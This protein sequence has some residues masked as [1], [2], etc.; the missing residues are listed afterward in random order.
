MHK[1]NKMAQSV[2]TQKTITKI[3]CQLYLVCYPQVQMTGSLEVY[4]F[5]K[6]TESIHTCRPIKQCQIFKNLISDILNVVSEAKLKG[7][8]NQKTNYL[9][10]TWQQPKERHLT[11]EVV[12]STSQP[13]AHYHHSLRER[14]LLEAALVQVYVQGIERD[15]CRPEPCKSSV[16]SSTFSRSCANMCWHFSVVLLWH[17]RCLKGKRKGC[18]FKKRG[19]NR[20]SCA[21]HGIYHQGSSVP[22]KT[23]CISFQYSLQ[24]IPHVLQRVLCIWQNQPPH[25]LAVI[26]TMRQLRRT[27]SFSPQGHIGLTETGSPA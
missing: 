11:S 27:S 25:P 20:A 15:G 18:F 1:T 13:S 23:C 21:L 10:L 7:G 19:R 17:C 2:K 12:D 3:C 22:Y 5:I 8:Q 16:P 26:M 24:D 14:G 4:V 9:I 6:Y